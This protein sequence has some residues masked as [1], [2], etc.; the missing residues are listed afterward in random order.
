MAAKNMNKSELV[1]AVAAQ[2]SGVSRKV[3]ADVI[4]ALIDVV[5][6]TV[7]KGGSVTLVGFGKFH[8]QERAARTGR[9]PATGAS[10]QIAASTVPKFT[11]G[12]AF[13]DRVASKK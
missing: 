6:E 12:K 8:A 5:T 1:E 2:A 13:K 3:T 9:N 11:C 7:A 10:M 4:D